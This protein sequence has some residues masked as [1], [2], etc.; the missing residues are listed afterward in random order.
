M[1]PKKITGA[2]DNAATGRIEHEA[3]GAASGAIVGAVVGVA[4]GPAGIAAGAVIGGIA[5]ALAGAVLDR[6]ASE[7]A[8]RTRE[9]DAAI[10]VSEG[11]LGAP[12]LKHP[13]AQ[14]GAYSAAS[15]GESRSGDS[16]P[17]EGPIQPPEA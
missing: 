17:A 3:E 9:L 14:R 8:A 4:A 11:S 7:Q 5:G 15:V 1:N 16:E 12:N 13:P 2:K 10:G 6:D